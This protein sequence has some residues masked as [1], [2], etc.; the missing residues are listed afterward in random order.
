MVA[1]QIIT[2]YICSNLIMLGKKLIS[3]LSGLSQNELDKFSKF[4]DSPY[5]NEQ[6]DLINIFTLIKPGLPHSIEK[7]P[8]KRQIWANLYPKK[9]YNDLKIRKLVSSLLT[10]AIS[11]KSYE[12]LNQQ[13][14]QKV[15]LALKSVSRADLNIH[16]ASI[17]RKLEKFLNHKS[18]HTAEAHFYAFEFEAQNHRILEK[19]NDLKQILKLELK[20]TRND[21]LFTI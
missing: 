17:N 8:K 20:S 5:H 3:F 7:I 13:P 1:Y 6:K 21:K 18:L 11:F 10:M 14:E 12:L 9:P 2:L 4:L 16:I 15:L 19:G